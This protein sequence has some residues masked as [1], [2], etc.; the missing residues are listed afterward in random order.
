MQ[1]LKKSAAFLLLCCLSV[2]LLY[3]CKTDDGVSLKLNFKPGD[4]FLYATE[5]NQKVNGNME[6]S[7]LMEMIYGYSGEEGGN[8]KLDITY[9]HI[10]INA[11]TPMGS[12][13]Y[14]SR[15]TSEGEAAFMNGL[16]GK[17]FTI[18]IA[19]NGDIVKIDGLG[20][21]IQALAG[22]ADS[23][24]KA[25]VESQFSDTAVRLMMQNSFDLY[26]GKN[27]KEGEEW[28]KKSTMSF[29]GINVNVENTYTLK[30]VK[31]GIASV[32]V[33]SRMDLPRMEMPGQGGVPMQIEM[34]GKQEGTME[35][36]LASGRIIS[37]KTTQQISGKI[38]AQ[39]N[40]MP[41]EIGG[42]ITISSKKI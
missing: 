5:V 10:R 27:V 34:K 33:S 31:D 23:E 40:E 38:S 28:G 4:K 16:I 42:D 3:S 17:T 2:C 19:P 30:S 18:T 6:Q 21:L 22:N 7:M 20:G 26:P 14:D 32:S 29:S 1:F 37:G 15:E 25:Q 36:E 11:T 35:V 8:K 9:D 13:L 24:T 39:G 41:M 12:S